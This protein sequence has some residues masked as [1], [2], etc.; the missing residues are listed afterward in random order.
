MW[1]LLAGRRRRSATTSIGVV[2]RSM[3]VALGLFLLMP[4]LA[5][6]AGQAGDVEAAPALRAGGPDDFG[7]TFKDSNEPGGPVYAWDEIAASGTLVTGWNNYDNGFAGPIPIGFDFKFYGTSYNHLYVGSNGYVSFGNGFGS[8]PTDSPLPHPSD[9]NNM[10]ALLAGDMYLHSYGN[11]SAVYYQ[12]LSNPTRLVVQFDRLNRCCSVY[13]EFTF[14][15]VVYPNGNIEARYEQLDYAYSYVIGI[16]NANGTDGLNYGAAPANGLAIRYTYPTGVLLA[17]PEQGSFGKRGAVV[18][19]SVRLTNR[20]GSPD[21]FDLAVQPGSDWPT[22][23]SI[24]QQPRPPCAAPRCSAP[25]R[26]AMSSPMLRCRIATKW[27]SLTLMAIVCWA[28]WTLARL[29]AKPPF[30]RPS[31]QLA[32]KSS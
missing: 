1:Q 28:S 17:P 31:H 24:S 6:L 18:R 12:T 29:A 8:I 11:S 26:S 30:A 2:A 7:Y 10:I 32:L 5:G 14:Q 21:S 13:D 27:R 25:Q 22:T 3:V 16:E 19:Y 9:P 4:A 23:L 15:V 20:T